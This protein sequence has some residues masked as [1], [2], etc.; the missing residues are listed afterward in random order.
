MR[1]Y[2]VNPQLAAEHGSHN[3]ELRNRFD[4]SHTID[5]LEEILDEDEVG[6]TRNLIP[7]VICGT[8][9]PPT[10]VIGLLNSIHEFLAPG[11]LARFIWKEWL[12]VNVWQ[13]A[14]L[15]WL[16]DDDND[17]S[18]TIHAINYGIP[19]LAPAS[20]WFK[21]LERQ[22]GCGIFLYET[23][24]EAL[25]AIRTIISRSEL[26]LRLKAVS[27]TAMEPVIALAAG[28]SFALFSDVR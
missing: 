14:A 28:K 7:L 19:V 11:S 24:L 12:D 18:L 1:S 10:E 6:Q 3:H 22:V 20:N 13:D 8:G 26:R 27:R 25:A 23:Y 15:L 2:I 17:Q 5:Q 4:E 16:W 21:G 9:S